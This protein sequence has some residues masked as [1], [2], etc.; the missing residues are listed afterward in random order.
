MED[1][2]V[3][4][5]SIPLQTDDYVEPS[6]VQQEPQEAQAQV[7]STS[8]EPIGDLT[9]AANQTAPEVDVDIM[10]YFNP[11]TGKVNEEYWDKVNVPKNLRSHVEQGLKSQID[12]F[13]NSLM[14]TAG[15]QEEYRKALAW[16]TKEWSDNQKKAYDVALSTNL[17]VAKL[18][19]SG[20]MADYRKANVSHQ[21]IEGQSGGSTVGT[22]YADKSDY[23]KDINT[24]QY[25]RSPAFRESV[26]Q[27]LLRSKK[28]GKI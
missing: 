19:V 4:R 23:L 11:A 1:N 9:I 5:V 3:N 15:G 16:A 25:K 2:K 27:K 6:G 17:D 28:A 24:D 8:Q 26:K 22:V 13:R 21:L 18:S 14:E 20:L 7:G 12:T 10:S